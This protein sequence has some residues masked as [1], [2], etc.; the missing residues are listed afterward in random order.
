MKIA[1][2]TR[3]FKQ[4]FYL[5]EHA[6][7]NSVRERFETKNSESSNTALKLWKN[8]NLEVAKVGAILTKQEM[9]SLQNL[10]DGPTPV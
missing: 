9:Q 7:K 3:Y 10:L 1:S 8:S 6:G 4:Q 2:E 5:L